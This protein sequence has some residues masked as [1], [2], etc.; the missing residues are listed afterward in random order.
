MNKKYIIANWKSNFQKKDIQNWLKIVG[1]ASKNCPAFLEVMIAPSFIHL[2]YLKEEIKKNNYSLKLCSQNVS[3]FSEGAYT[4]EVSAKQI[5]EYVNFVIIGHSERRKYFGENNEMISQKVLRTLDCNLTPIICISDIDF[6][7]QINFVTG[8]LDK[9]Q[10][11][12]IIFM[13]EP[14][15]AISKQ[16]GPIGKGEA[17][18]LE[19]V[20]SM[21]LQIK[22]TAP[23]SRVFY[24][25]SVKSDNIAQFLK[26]KDIAGVVIG[27]ASLN[28]P[29]FIKIILYASQI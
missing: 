12:N 3:P 1:P 20:N 25:G 23:D 26:Q 13:Y 28:G 10:M 27:S 15:S 4:G 17:A 9:K 5:S 8:I 16:V 24:G 21:V 11:Q 18:P 19:E 14:P 22:K 29:E 2:E 6:E 7:K